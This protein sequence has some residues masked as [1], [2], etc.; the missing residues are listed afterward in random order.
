MIDNTSELRIL[1]HNK[2]ILTD[3]T[4]VMVMF[5]YHAYLS[6]F[7]LFRFCILTLSIWMICLLNENKVIYF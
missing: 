6:Y 4:L 7:I 3:N 1:F 5:G 2:Y